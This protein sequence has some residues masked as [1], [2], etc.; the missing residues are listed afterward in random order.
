MYPRRPPS[1]D[2]C[3]PPGPIP[4][5]IRQFHW[6]EQ[7]GLNAAKVRNVPKVGSQFFKLL[8]TLH[9]KKGHEG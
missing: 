1:V 2:A 6:F 4:M 5:S 7:W 3:A 9:C 8:R